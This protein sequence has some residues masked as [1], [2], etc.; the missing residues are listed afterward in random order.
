MIFYLLKGQGAEI[1]TKNFT[2]IKRLYS[3]GQNLILIV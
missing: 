3:C 2:A 1:G